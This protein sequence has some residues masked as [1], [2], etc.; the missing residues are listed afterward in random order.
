[1]FFSELAELVEGRLPDIWVICAAVE[2]SSLRFELAYL[3]SFYGGS[4]AILVPVGSQSPRIRVQIPE[5]VINRPA[6]TILIEPTVFTILEI[7][8]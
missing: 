2:G 3:N 8:N 5:R 7:N 4:E 1:M 6:S